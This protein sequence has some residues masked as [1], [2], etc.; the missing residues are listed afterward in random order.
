M[1]AKEDLVPLLLQDEELGDSTSTIS[2][3]SNQADRLIQETVPPMRLG[4]PSTSRFSFLSLA[5]ELR[6][7][8]YRYLLTAGDEYIDIR[9]PRPT[10]KLHTSMI[11]TS[12]QIAQEAMAILYCENFFLAR[13]D[14]ERD[15]F[16]KDERRPRDEKVPM[17]SRH[18]KSQ[19]KGDMKESFTR[20]TGHIYPH[21]FG[22]MRYLLLIVKFGCCSRRNKFEP[23]DFHPEWVAASLREAVDA[24]L[25]GGITIDLIVEVDSLNMGRLVP[26]PTE[27]KTALEPLLALQKMK[28]LQIIE[29]DVTRYGLS[30]KDLIRENE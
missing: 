26:S 17:S 6:N 7:E 1:S 21:V 8:V 25:S 28:R 19:R 24:M 2:R 20:G 4:E 18:G 27:V 16:R 9:Q 12:R 13:L 14:H 23:W 11:Y 5:P 29:Y 30:V 15:F 10:S 22:R 3:I